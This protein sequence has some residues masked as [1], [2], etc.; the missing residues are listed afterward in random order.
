MKEIIIGLGLIT[1]F[2]I[3]T[4]CFQVL[5]M[6]L[7]AA[8]GVLLFP[9]TLIQ[10]LL[11]TDHNTNRWCDGHVVN[12]SNWTLNKAK[13]VMLDNKYARAADDYLAYKAQQQ[14]TD[15]HAE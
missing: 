10:N 3:L 11:G 15:D 8:L 2:V 7:R 4:T 13:N 9:I 12:G 14:S 6:V 1:M 5:V